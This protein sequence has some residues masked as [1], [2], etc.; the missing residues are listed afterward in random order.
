MFLQSAIGIVCTKGFEILDLDECVCHWDI[1][2]T[3]TQEFMRSFNSVIIPNGE[4]AKFSR[5]FA[6][7]KPL[8][9]F[10]CGD[11][12]LLLVYSGLESCLNICTGS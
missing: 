1:T 4:N 5:Q 3:L 11:G 6:A 9:I 2:L 10:P 8:S 12:R 7:C